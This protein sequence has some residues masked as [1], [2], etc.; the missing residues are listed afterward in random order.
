MAGEIVIRNENYGYWNTNNM[1]TYA[2]PFFIKLTR[3]LWEFKP[4]FMILGECYGGFMFEN[5]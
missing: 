5:R 2:N 1:E 4:N 3:R